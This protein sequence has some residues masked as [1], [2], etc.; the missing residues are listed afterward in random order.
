MQE[1]CPTCHSENIYQDRSLW[2]CPE[3]SNEWNET[4]E[5]EVTEGVV[6]DTT[7]RDANGNRLADGDAIIVVKDL[8]L[9]G[10][11]TIVK[12]GTKARNIRVINDGAGH[13]LVCKID[14]LGAINLKS[15]FVKKV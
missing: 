11:S 8:K 5:T 7:V 3:C 4:K 9:K 10:S 6:E 14:G 12:S 1:R 15:E 13:N 2:I